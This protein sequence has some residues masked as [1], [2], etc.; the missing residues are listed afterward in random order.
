MGHHVELRR[1]PVDPNNSRS[2]ANFVNLI[3]HEGN[4]VKQWNLYGDGFYVAYPMAEVGGILVDPGF[5][6]GCMNWYEQSADLG[7]GGYRC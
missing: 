4:H 6:D 2:V 7:K 5:E 1:K 3:E